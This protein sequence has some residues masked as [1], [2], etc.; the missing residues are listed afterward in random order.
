MR[1]VHD[2]AVPISD[3]MCSLYYTVMAVASAMPS[4]SV[5]S[6]QVYRCLLDGETYREPLRMRLEVAPAELEHVMDIADP[7]IQEVET[8]AR[9]LVLLLCC[10]MNMISIRVV[11]MSYQRRVLKQSGPSQS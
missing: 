2:M 4:A 3:T 8:N 7:G 6:M 11:G 5:H 1:D 9:H 10:I